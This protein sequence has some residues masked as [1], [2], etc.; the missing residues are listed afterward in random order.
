MS[1]ELLAAR[2]NTTT[3]ELTA[4]IEPVL[5]S[6]ELSIHQF[7]NYTS[8]PKA[9]PRKL[10]QLSKCFCKETLH[11]TVL[12]SPQTNGPTLVGTHHWPRNHR[13][14]LTHVVIGYLRVVQH[15]WVYEIPPGMDNVHYIASLLAPLTQNM[16]V[17]SFFK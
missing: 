16:P 6:F 8:I 15:R 11:Y 2:F 5:A 14:L 13:L 1:I 17:V 7:D 4:I 12:L 9:L 10:L 3:N